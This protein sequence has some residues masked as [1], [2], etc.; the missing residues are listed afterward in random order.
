MR[1]LP[2]LLVAL[3]A[4]LVARPSRAAEGRLAVVPLDAPPELTFMGKSAADA[5]AKEAARGGGE[6]LAPS[7]VEARL[8]RDATLALVRCGDD[9]RC[10][11][12]RAAALGVDRVVGGRLRKQGE[13][14]RVALVHADART[15]ALLGGLERQS[16]VA[17]RRLQR[18]VAAAAGALL[19][20]G[21]DA[22]GVLEVVTV[23]AGALVTIDDVPMGTTPVS[24]P[25]KPG[26]HKVHV[27]QTGYADAEPVWIEVPAS[28]T[29]KHHPRMYEIP[30]RD[31][32]NQSA[33]E[34]GGTKVRI[35]K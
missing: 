22:S 26:R 8:G 2:C 20:G 15:G 18:D 11:A 23:P 31:R 1:T 29:V 6:V 28:G 12:G 32:P 14:Y 13:T 5:F 21:E 10:L 3:A 4:A 16:P 17:S 33:S 19:G 24:R 9:A 27:A 7:A 35:V 34:G 25:V 30:A